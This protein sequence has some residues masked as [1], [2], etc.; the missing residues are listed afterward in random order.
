MFT[1]IIKPVDDFLNNITMY[2]LVLYYLIA[3]WLFAFSVSFFKFLPFNPIQLLISSGIILTTCFIFNKFLAKAF[4]AFTN[5]ESVYISALIL[6]LLITP[7]KNISDYYFIIAAS[8]ITI[9]SKYI[10]ALKNKHFFNPVA[11]AVF[12]TSVIS[13]GSASWWIGTSIMLPVVFI[14]GLLI[15]RKTQKIELISFFLLSAFFVISLFSF[16]KGFDILQTIYRVIFDS[17]II[18]FSF[19]MLTEPLTMPPTKKLQ[20]IYATF[21]GILFSPQIHILNFYTT[22]EISLLIGNI[23]SYAVSPK[24]K[25]YLYLKEKIKISSDIYDFIFGIDKKFNFIPGQY[26]E[27]TLNVNNSDSRGNRRYFTISS[28]PT[29]DDLRIGVKFYENSSSFKKNLVDLNIGDKILGGNLSGEFTIQDNEN[30]KLVFVAGGIGITPF[31]SIIKYL[32]DK[33]IKIDI[34]I[35]FSNKLKE[36]IVYKDIFDQAFD[37]LNIKTY[38]NLTD[39]ENIPNDWQ[40]EKGRI[41]NQIIK[42]YVPDF[43]ERYFYLSGPHTMVSGFEE[44]LIN[45]GISKNKIKKDFFPGFV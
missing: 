4:N 22:P 10:F 32:L 33:N 17:P 12:I 20:I 14:G 16:I 41:N 34:V 42:K 7:G 37:K 19:V 9:S 8:I 30:K 27:W 6:I 36:E 11:I 39:L 40:G 5:L 25:I 38:Y 21:V 45:M 24:E 1:K 44:V 43:N 31:R 29:E 23:F 28:S 18:F 3:L 35:L 2:R 15:I 26:L 13:L